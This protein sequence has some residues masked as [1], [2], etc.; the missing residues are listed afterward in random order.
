MYNLSIEKCCLTAVAKVLSAKRQ[1]LV[2]AHGDFVGF[3][4]KLNSSVWFGRYNKTNELC[5]GTI[6]VD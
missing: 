3:F 5:F 1:W 2:V 4:C 6:I